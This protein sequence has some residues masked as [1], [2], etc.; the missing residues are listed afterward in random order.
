MHAALSGMI[1]FNVQFSN[2]RGEPLIIMR[3]CR[4]E[5]FREIFFLA[6]EALALINIRKPRNS[7]QRQVAFLPNFARP[8]PQWLMVHS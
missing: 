4:A 3:R 1:R 7:R 5:I 6:N 8:P 2:E